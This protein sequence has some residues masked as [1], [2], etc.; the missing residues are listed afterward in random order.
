MTRTPLE[1]DPNHEYAKSRPPLIEIEPDHW[2]VETPWST[3]GNAQEQGV[4][5]TTLVE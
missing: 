1:V 4:D 5:L 2:V 3:I